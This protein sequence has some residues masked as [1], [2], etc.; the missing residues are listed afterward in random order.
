MTAQLVC[1]SGHVTSHLQPARLRFAAGDFRDGTS[2]HTCWHLHNA[3]WTCL[4]GDHA[5]PDAAASGSQGIWRSKVWMVPGQNLSPLVMSY[6]T[7]GNS[8]NL[9]EPV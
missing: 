5:G 8:F 4:S 7:V 3:K 6:V 1:P 2:L 9:S